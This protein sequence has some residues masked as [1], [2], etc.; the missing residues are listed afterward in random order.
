VKISPAA[1]LSF[2]AEALIEERTQDLA[3]KSASEAGAAG[4]G[5]FGLSPDFANKLLNIA[6]AEERQ[7][8]RAGQGATDSASSSPLLGER[9]REVLELLAAGLSYRQ[10]AYK[11]FIAP[12]TVKVH[13]HNTIK[14]LN[15]NNRASAIA[16]AKELKL[17]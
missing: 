6:R 8:N 11:L 2:L 15:V 4:N 14:K 7:N 1:A 17:F 5:V 13:I 12:G 9:E 16:R 10:I 3:R